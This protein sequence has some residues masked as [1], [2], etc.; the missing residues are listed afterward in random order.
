[1]SGT[2]TAGLDGSRESL[3]AADWAARE[4]L[5]RGA[6]LRLVHAWGQPPR[7]SAATLAGAT[8]PLPDRRWSVRLLAKAEVILKR[9]HPGLQIVTEPLAGEPVAALVTAAQD[10]EVLVLGSRGLGRAAGILLGSVG[11]GVVAR[12]GR[13]VVLVRDGAPGT[14]PFAG[15]EAPSESA[16]P[17]DVVLGLDLERPHEA[18]L[19]FAFDAASRRAAALRVVHGG[20]P[21]AHPAPD[22][23]AGT[24]DGG[25]S[26]EAADRVQ[27][28][29][30]DLLRP[31]R[32]KYPGVEVTE[33]AVI[34]HPGAHLAD[35]SRDAALLVV[36]RAGRPVPVGTHI[37]PVTQA[38]LRHAAVPVA[39][40]PHD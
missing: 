11:Q 5:L 13:P 26:E 36:G 19:E 25:A 17:H 23:A 18:V 12:V 2:V 38:V 7:V 21:S 10:T 29:S 39:V 30:M 28:R 24:R 8:V 31:W 32:E 4:A 37:G 6:T 9:R 1:M 15:S 33:Q 3:A 35:V 16:A 27:R 20:S 14:S 40:V 22:T 34:G